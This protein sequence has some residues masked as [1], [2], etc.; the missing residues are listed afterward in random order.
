VSI[1]SLFRCFLTFCLLSVAL[2]SLSQEEF[3][4]SDGTLIYSHH[5]DPS[6]VKADHWEILL[7]K[8]G[9]KPNYVAGNWGLITKPTL[10]GVKKE[11][12]GAQRFEKRYEAFMGISWGPD[13]Y[14]NPSPP[15]AVTKAEARDAFD[16]AQEMGSN[17]VPSQQDFLKT[18]HIPKELKE[19]VENLKD[20][21]SRAQTLYKVLSI[22]T[23]MFPQTV[24]RELNEGVSAVDK[25]VAYSK[26]AQPFQTQQA[27]PPRSGASPSLSADQSS[28]L[29]KIQGSWYYDIGFNTIEHLTVSVNGSKVT[30]TMTTP[31]T[32]AAGGMTCTGSGGWTSQMSQGTRLDVIALTP[33]CS[34]ES[35]GY[36]YAE[37]EYNELDD[38]IDVSMSASQNADTASLYKFSRSNR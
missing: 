29:Q 13:T 14:F 27:T 11:L 34:G 19:Y 18:P 6:Q 10:D 33:T 21:M 35:Y 12:E 2:P 9:D 5:G 1:G 30:M 4:T 17:E 7:F 15:I 3:L 25:S 32:L 26:S 23:S 24:G 8:R 28:I 22:P 38:S 37:I 36:K 20:G 16:Q 31:R